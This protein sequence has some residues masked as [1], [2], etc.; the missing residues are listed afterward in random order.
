MTRLHD[1]IR[2]VEILFPKNLALPS[3]FTSFIFF[4]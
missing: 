3:Y 1:E 2:F 4:E